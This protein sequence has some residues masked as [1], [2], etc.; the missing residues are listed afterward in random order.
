MSHNIFFFKIFVELLKSSSPHNRL[1]PQFTSFKLPTA[2]NEMVLLL[3]LDFVKN[4]AHNSI[5]ILSVQISN[6]N[7]DNVCTE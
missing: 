2:G 1:L 7:N 5:N 3:L 6:Y 4:S